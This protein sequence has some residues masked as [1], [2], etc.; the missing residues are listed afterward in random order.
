MVIIL[1]TAMGMAGLVVIIVAGIVHMA[2]ELIDTGATGIGVM[3]GNGS[4]YDVVAL[5]FVLAMALIGYGTVSDFPLAILIGAVLGVGST[6]TVLFQ[7][8]E[9]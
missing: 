2:M 5:V 4:V 1:A 9:R 8:M 3:V 7:L 6:L